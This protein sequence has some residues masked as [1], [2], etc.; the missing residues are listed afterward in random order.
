MAIHRLLTLAAVLQVAAISV[1]VHAQAATD[2]VSVDA[3]V[4]HLGVVTVSG[5]QLTS[6]PTQ[7]PATMEGITREQ[8]EQS[9]NATDSEDALKRN[10]RIE[11]KL[12]DR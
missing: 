10:R 11:L 2:A 4:R 8:I 7:I 3:P 5:G 9:I 6:L 12:T 1:S